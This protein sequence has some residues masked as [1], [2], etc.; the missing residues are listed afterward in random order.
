MIIVVLLAKEHVRIIARAH[1]PAH[2]LLYVRV[3]AAINVIVHVLELVILLVVVHHLAAVEGHLQITEVVE[4]G[5]LVPTVVEGVKTLA[6]V[7]VKGRAR[8]VV[9]LDAQALAKDHAIHLVSALVKQHVIL[10]AILHVLVAQAHVWDLAK[11]LVCTPVMSHAQ[12]H[13]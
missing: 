13:A 11:G 4:I 6:R 3:H 9:V 12:L 7:D 10:R 2:V 8:A 1:V 5:L